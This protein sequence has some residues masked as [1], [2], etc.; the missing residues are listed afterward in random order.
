VADQFIITNSVPVPAING[1]PGKY[2]FGKMEKG[3]SFWAETTKNNL[4]IQAK[5]FVRKHK[6]EW[7]FFAFKE[8]EGTRIWRIE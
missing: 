7:K 4:L 5:L 8:K 1:R 2:P 3:S 6:L